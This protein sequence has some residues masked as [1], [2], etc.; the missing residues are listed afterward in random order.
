VE[1]NVPVP[2][3]RY[4][5]IDTFNAAWRLQLE[6]IVTGDYTIPG[7]QIIDYPTVSNDSRY[8]FSLFAFPEEEFPNVVT[9]F[10]AFC[11]SYYQ[12]KGYRSILYV[13]YFIAQD[14][15]SQLSYS[16]DGNVMT[17]DPVSTGNPGWEDYLVAYNQFC[18][19]RKGRGLLNQTPGLTA[20]MLQK[21]CG[22]RLQALKTARAQ[23][24][25]NNRLLND[26]FRQLLA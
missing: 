19:D 12:Q 2:S 1:Q 22:D 25:P 23:Y 16:W 18:I 8:T 24:D 11:K 20:G 5:I 14:Q 7:D 10:F 3:L 17:I 9:D 15:K 21:F 6:T 4:G 13:G 26:Y